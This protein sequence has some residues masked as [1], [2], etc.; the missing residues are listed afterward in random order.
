MSGE[1]LEQ[2]VSEQGEVNTQ[3]EQSEAPEVA[4]PSLS[5]SE[6][7]ALMEALLFANGEPLSI[8]RIQEL[9]GMAKGE[10]LG[11]ADKLAQSL[12]QS[13]RGIELVVVAEKLQLRTRAKFAD[14]VRQL[15]AV[16]PRKLS[17]AALETLAVVAYQQ[18]VVKSE[19]DKIRGV[20][21]APTI[22]TLLE[23]KLV[24]IIGYQASVGQPALYGTTEEFLQVFGLPALSALP[25]IQDLKALVREPGEAQV[26]QD[27]SAEQ[28]NSEG[29][30]GATSAEV[31]CAPTQDVAAQGA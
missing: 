11:L 14:Y 22:K 6:L 19:I 15:M 12:N 28:L 1:D 21:V 23:R 18:P 30:E 26:E 5:E 8:A 16:R 10:V 31:E 7:V 4:R 29:D 2:V 20:D 17:Q 24:K 27:E 9:L 3:S 25:S 13:E